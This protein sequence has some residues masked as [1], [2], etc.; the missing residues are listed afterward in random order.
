MNM[1][2][3]QIQVFNFKLPKSL[4]DTVLIRKQESSKGD[5]NWAA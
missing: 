5:L 3:V 2:N 4:S 1:K